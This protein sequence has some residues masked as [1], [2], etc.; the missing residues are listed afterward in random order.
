MGD[1]LLVYQFGGARA[2]E[3]GAN[4]GKVVDYLGAGQYEVTRI[5]RISGDSLFVSPGLTHTYLPA[6]T[7]LVVDAR[8]EARTVGNLTAPDFDGRTGGILFLT[9]TEHLRVT[10]LLDAAGRGFRGGRGVQKSD[11]CIFLSA[12][13]DYT[14]AD[15][16]FEGTRRGEGITPLPAGRELGRAPLANGGGGGNDH[17]SGGGGGANWSGGGRGGLNITNSPFRCS[18]R[19]PGM[20]GY[21]LHD[22]Y[23][24]IYFGGG[25]G[26]GHA[27]NTSAAGGGAGGG[28]VVLWA[29]TVTFVEGGAVRVNG[30]PG[31]SV[32]GDGA[33]GGGAAG[34]ILILADYTT[35]SA[36]LLLRGG[37][38]GNTDNQSDRCF[39]PG[40]GGAGG[41]LLISNDFS[42][43]SLTEDYAG[44]AAG[45]RIGSSICQP[46]DGP[47]EPGWQGG[48]TEITFKRPVSR[49]T[50]SSP[51]ACPSDLITVI[52]RHTGSDSVSWQILPDT[53]GLRTS[54]TADG[55][56]IAVSK[57]AIGTYAVTQT[58]YAAGN[59]YPGDT[60]RFVVAEAA[61]ADSIVAER[62]GD[63]V[64][65]RVINGSGYDSIRYAFGDGSDITT[66]QPTATH[67]YTT[68][69]AFTVTVTLFNGACGA[70]TLS[71][72]PPP[73]R[74]LTRALIL[75]KDPTGCPPLII[76]PFALSQGNY[77]SRRWDF[78]GGEPATST[79][80]KP[81]VIYRTP[82]I[83]TVTLTLSGSTVGGDT[84]ATLRVTVFD[85]PTAGFDYSWSDGR[86]VFTNRSENAV[87]SQWF[88][89]DGSTSQEDHPVHAYPKDSTYLVTLVTTGPSC[90]DTLRR[91][92][93]T[94][95]LATSRDPMEPEIW[96]YPNPTEGAVYVAGPARIIGVLDAR[97]R[98][99]PTGEDTV[100]LGPLPP[101]VYFIRLQTSRGIRTV[102][103]VKS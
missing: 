98:R 48:L 81:S 56:T 46:T 53:T 19:Y 29:P 12:S 2:T 40:G 37:G 59:N 39:G 100:D 49:F 47:A 5:T 1:A 97:G 7:Q 10:G 85:A 72:T 15:G 83:Y 95:P 14:Y 17:N 82:G 34:T 67:R 70:L 36:N 44:G 32:S 8:V 68:T 11:D 43:L 84:I 52:D 41:R 60:L 74:Q 101:G 69:G 9:A 71:T 103:V 23:G 28:I 25:G 20:G 93:S 64:R 66:D 86:V 76:T 35:G 80:E 73:P 75:E 99:L 102:R 90:T 24:R 33:G 96:V 63:S 94:L 3:S 58:L 91:E 6:Y 18:G 79:E 55:F 26:A 62:M 89:G 61:A 92:V 87:S 16:S 30:A 88:F 21:G 31:A 4:A 27:N 13:D 51:V 22:D 77:A 54:T 78:P 42:E 57:R 45:I 38:G 50:L 65:V